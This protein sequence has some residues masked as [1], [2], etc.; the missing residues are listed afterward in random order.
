[1]ARRKVVYEQIHPEAKQGGAP[2]KAGGGKVAKGDNVSSFADDTAA[3]TG[4]SPRTVQHYAQ[5]AAKI[6]PEA[7]AL[8]RDTPLA[9]EKRDL[10]RIARLP[11]EKQERARPAGARQPAWLRSGAAFAASVESGVAIPSAR[12]AGGRYISSGDPSTE[13]PAHGAGPG[14]TGGGSR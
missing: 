3:R 12:R 5:I 13:A 10:T 6:T 8:L 9:D 4:V 2:G 1:L 7:K 14:P 11:A